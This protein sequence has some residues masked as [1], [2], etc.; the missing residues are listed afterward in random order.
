MDLNDLVKNP[1][2]I[3]GLITILQTLL[4]SQGPQA[5]DT[6][7]DEQPKAAKKRSK[8]TTKSIKKQQTNQR[9]NKF[10]SMPEKNLHKEDTEIDKKLQK[11]PPTPRSR[12]FRPMKATCRVCGRTENVSPG[13][14]TTEMDRYKCN[15]CSGA[16][17]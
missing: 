13:Y 11:L 16:A 2:Q 15:K 3:K 1:E 4:D 12:K 7:G 9:E 6:D 10:L 8:N 14:M 17:G 5:D